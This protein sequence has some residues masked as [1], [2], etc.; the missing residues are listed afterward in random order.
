MP[1]FTAP[2]LSILLTVLLISTSNPVMALDWRYLPESAQG[3]YR[4]LL[5]QPLKQ[6]AGDYPNGL[7]GQGSTLELRPT[8]RRGW[9]I[10]QLGIRTGREEAFQEERGAVRLATQDTE[11]S[12]ARDAGLPAGS[13][14]PDLFEDA[15]TEIPLTLDFGILI[16]F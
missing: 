4:P 7:P 13:Q 6:K 2:V 12:R 3:N 11:Q 10:F 15:F 5:D 16:T 8:P 1:P 9:D 14:V